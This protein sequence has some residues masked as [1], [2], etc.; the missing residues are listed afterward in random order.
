MYIQVTDNLTLRIASEDYS[1][2]NVTV[3]VEW[4]QLA[5][6]A[7]YTV[8]VVPLVPIVSTGSTNCQ[9]T[10]SYNMEYN[11][12]VEATIAAP[13]R[14]NATA[15]IRLKYGEVYSHNLS[16]HNELLSSVRLLLILA[17]CREPE[18]ISP[19]ESVPRVITGYDD[20][21]PV[22]DTTIMLS[23][24]PGLVLIGA[25]SATCMENGEW[26]PNPSGV[27]CNG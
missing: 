5:V 16:V 12:T 24:P 10:I 26:E 17:N 11:L 21:I 18:F 6:Y 3:T 25:S 8:T 13:C 14:L 19:V 23:C 20:V 9:L 15:V 22:E 27:T 1:P 7:K 4:T 2:D